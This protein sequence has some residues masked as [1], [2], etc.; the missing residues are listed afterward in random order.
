MPGTP[1]QCHTF[2]IWQ[3][4]SENTSL[5]IPFC[6]ITASIFTEILIGPLTILIGSCTDL[7]VDFGS[8][9]NLK[10]W[11]WLL[12]QPKMQTREESTPA[13]WSSLLSVQYSKSKW[14]R[15][16]AWKWLQKRMKRK[17]GYLIDVQ[18]ST[19]IKLATTQDRQTRVLTNATPK[20]PRTLPKNP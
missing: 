1:T 19:D 14:C 11:L 3:R 20:I 12:L 4:W 17:I 15:P 13:P 9:S 16:S 2:V 7:D 6:Y 18:F 5:L 10:Y 8:C